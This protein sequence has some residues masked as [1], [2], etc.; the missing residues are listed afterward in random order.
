MQGYL[1][2]RSIKKKFFYALQTVKQTWNT[3]LKI[4]ATE[5]KKLSSTILKQKTEGFL[6][7]WGE[8]LEKSWRIFHGRLVS[9]IRPSVF[10]NFLFPRLCSYPLLRHRDWKTEEAILSK[11]DPSVEWRPGPWGR[12]FLACKTGK[13]LEEDL[14]HKRAEKVFIWNFSEVNIL[15]KKEARGP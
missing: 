1:G 4:V 6:S 14:H 7:T 13:H 15:R 3:S 12:H 10:A 2:I 8:L 9:G 5:D 11:D